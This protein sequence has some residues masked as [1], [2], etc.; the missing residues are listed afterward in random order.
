MP[1]NFSFK[2]LCHVISASSL[3]TSFLS[4]HDAFCICAAPKHPLF[5][6]LAFAPLSLPSQIILNHSKLIALVFVFET[7]TVESSAFC[8]ARKQPATLWTQPGNRECSGISSSPALASRRKKINNKEKQWKWS[9]DRIMQLN[10]PHHIPQRQRWCWSSKFLDNRKLLSCNG[11]QIFHLGCE[12]STSAPT[13][14]KDWCYNSASVQNFQ[15]ES[16][17]DQLGVLTWVCVYPEW[18]KKTHVTM[19]EME[20]RIYVQLNAF[21]MLS[22]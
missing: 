6:S 19:T 4:H 11:T 13:K 3:S 21:T 9:Q 1:T 18:M 22:S 5:H 20:M 7:E 8:T 15:T 16:I 12:G 17:S 10:T 14:G 2:N